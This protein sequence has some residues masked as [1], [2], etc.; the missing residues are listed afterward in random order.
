M[1]MR[2]GLEEHEILRRMKA[3]EYELG[4]GL[5]KT[6]RDMRKGFRDKYDLGDQKINVAM[7]TAML[8]NAASAIG[9]A[10]CPFL[11]GDEDLAMEKAEELARS[12]RICLS[13]WLDEHGPGEL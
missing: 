11:N 5:A 10:M 1:V 12:L 7:A 13:D 9:G 4:E 8:D 3:L 2:L 6:M